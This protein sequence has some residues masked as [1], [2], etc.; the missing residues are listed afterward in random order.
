MNGNDDNDD[1]FDIDR[2]EQELEFLTEK[3]NPEEELRYRPRSTNIP[4]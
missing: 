3:R 1:D 2:P 4:D